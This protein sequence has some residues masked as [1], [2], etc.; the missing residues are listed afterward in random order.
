MGEPPTAA[1]DRV[2]SALAVEVETWPGA[3]GGSCAAIVRLD[4]GSLAVLGYTLVCGPA[5]QTDEA[6][7]R[8]TADADALFLNEGAGHGSAHAVGGEWVFYQ[9]SADFAGGSAVS[10]RNGLTVFAGTSL[11]SGEG[12]L[13]LPAKWST[14]D[15]G[16]GCTFAMSTISGFDFRSGSPLTGDE[17]RTAAEVV[18]GS[19]LPRSMRS[20]GFVVDTVVLLYPRTIDPFVPNNAEYLVL[21]NVVKGTL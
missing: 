19:A 13:L 16:N 14:S 6:T 8:A 12:S 3:K 10:R 21:L 11:S 1:C 7:A 20:L 17:A 5:R 9:S 4:Y 15:I 2:A 18:L